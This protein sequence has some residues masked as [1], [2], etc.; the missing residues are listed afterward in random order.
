LSTPFPPQQPDARL[1]LPPTLPAGAPDPALVADG[2][3]AGVPADDRIGPAPVPQAQAGTATSPGQDLS[4][5]QDDP[6][7]GFI[8]PLWLAGIG[9]IVLFVSIPI[10]PGVLW[11]LLIA[12]WTYP[13]HRRLSAG[14]RPGPA[15]GVSTVLLVAVAILPTMWLVESTQLVWTWAQESLPSTIDLA[16][17][18]IHEIAASLPFLGDTLQSTL[19]RTVRDIDWIG[20]GTGSANAIGGMLTAVVL[21]AG[22]WAF[23]LVIGIG[24]LF[25]AYR[26]GPLWWQLASDAAAAS[27]GVAGREAATLCRQTASAVTRGVILTAIVQGAL[28]GLGYWAAGVPQPLLL[29]VIT[30]PAAIVPLG[31]SLVWVP[32]AAWL[33]LTGEVGAGLGLALWGALAVSTADNALRPWLMHEHTTLSFWPLT[34]AIIGGTLALGVPG[35]YVGPIAY[36]LARMAITRAAR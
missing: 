26:D 4:P 22:D 24:T 10:L 3:P 31:A 12:Y 36:S 1:P 19:P 6:V 5:A 27:F 28:A 15:A 11:A 13:L 16:L 2:L 20:V 35:V 7:R 14:L 9:A 30:V 32:A 33:A 18:R 29:A 25:F 8:A 21:R 23:H 34:L 17:T